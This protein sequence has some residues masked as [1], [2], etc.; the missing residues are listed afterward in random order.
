MPKAISEEKEKEKCNTIY[1]HASSRKVFWQWEDLSTAL[2]K[3]GP[4]DFP[5]EKSFLP[6]FAHEKGLRH[7]FQ[8]KFSCSPIPFFFA[9]PQAKNDCSDCNNESQIV[10]VAAR[11][12]KSLKFTL[13]I[14]VHHRGSLAKNHFSSW[15]K[16]QL[17][18]IMSCETVYKS[19][20]HQLFS[21]NHS[22]LMLHLFVSETWF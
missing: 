10:A 18:A 13:S 19:L 4:L 7:M 11:W 6:F 12:S 17:K 8:K 5:L 20:T 16:R 2:A 22:W 21:K 9:S 3:S 14:A 1:M 15:L